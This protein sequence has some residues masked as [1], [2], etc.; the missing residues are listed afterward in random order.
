MRNKQ[1]EQAS[2]A[3]KMSKLARVI[4]AKTSLGDAEIIEAVSHIDLDKQYSIQKVSPE[5]FEKQAQNFEE[6]IN[7]IGD[8]EEKIIH[9][10]NV[11]IQNEIGGICVIE[12]THIGCLDLK[13]NERSYSIVIY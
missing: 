12:T 6:P 1:F 7:S 13:K 10:A 9:D 3:E 8:W 11:L 5:D 4:K 2:S